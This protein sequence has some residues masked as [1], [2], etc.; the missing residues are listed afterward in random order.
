M[1]V[2]SKGPVRLS[3]TFTPTLA[4][5]VWHS[6]HRTAMVT[7]VLLPLCWLPAAAQLYNSQR[8]SWTQI[9]G[10]RHS[11]LILSTL[12][13]MPSTA[14]LTT[15]NCQ[16]QTQHHSTASS[17]NNASTK[18]L[19]SM[20]Q[21]LTDIAQ[22]VQQKAPSESRQQA[23]TMMKSLL[24]PST[25]QQPKHREYR[26]M[27]L[28]SAMLLVKL[29][30]LLGTVPAASATTAS[31]HRALWKTLQ[32]L[33][34]CPPALQE[35]TECCQTEAEEQS[36]LSV[37]LVQLLVPIMHQSLKGNQMVAEMC[38][39]LLT[40]LLSGVWEQTFQQVTSELLH[41]GKTHALIPNTSLT[42]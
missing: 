41:L 10:P 26:N 34:G 18:P 25:E 24:H 22:S 40:W 6:F 36:H 35:S 27:M 14:L 7:D 31:A 9:H 1:Q 39:H 38:C 13:G 29:A 37:L 2:Q 32:S 16:W 8:T 30:S 3:A 5:H 4:F 28:D 11:V 42:S 20:V 12:S 33:C 21:T 15:D 17:S 19:M 23:D